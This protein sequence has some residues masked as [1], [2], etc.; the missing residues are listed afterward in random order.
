MAQNPLLTMIPQDP[1]SDV[2]SPTALYPQAPV[3][4][5]PKPAGWMPGTPRP[6]KPGAPGQPGAVGQAM[7]QG[8]STFTDFGAANPASVA[9][10]MGFSGMIPGMP[11]P[12]DGSGVVPP[13]G[14]HAAMGPQAP[15]INPTLQGLAPPGQKPPMADAAGKVPGMEGYSGTGYDARAPQGG[16]M[17]ADPRFFHPAGAPQAPE[18]APMQTLAD[19]FQMRYGGPQTPMSTLPPGMVPPAPLGEAGGWSLGTPTAP[20]VPA[21]MPGYAAGPA[22]PPGALPAPGVSYAG[23]SPTFREDQVTPTTLSDAKKAAAA[24]TA[25]PAALPQTDAAGSVK[26]TAGQTA[27]AA[28]ESAPAAQTAAST[29]LPPPQQ[30]TA[31][32]SPSAWQQDPILSNMVQ[33]GVVTRIPLDGQNGGDDAFN[34]FLAD[35][36]ANSD[37][38]AAKRL[39]NLR[40]ALS[41]LKGASPGKQYANRLKD[42]QQALENLQK[43]DWYKGAGVTFD[44]DSLAKDATSSGTGSWTNPVTPGGSGTGG[45]I[46]GGVDPT[47]GAPTV[48]QLP[49]PGNMNLP[50][51]FR[52]WAKLGPAGAQALDSYLK[53]LG[54]QQSDSNRQTAVDTYGAFVNQL[55]NDPTRAAL[56]DFL[57]N[58]AGQA[59]LSPEMIEAMKTSGRQTADSSL[60]A[61]DEQVR[62]LAAQT[63]RPVSDFAPQIAQGRANIMSDLINSNRGVDIQGAMQGANDRANQ[64]NYLTAGQGA[65]YGM[66]GNAMGSQANLIA[67]TPNLASV[68]F[69]W[70][71]AAV[72]NQMLQFQN[73]STNSVATGLSGM[74]SG[75]ASGAKIG[76][77]IPGI[78]TLAGGIGGGLLG[79]ASGFLQ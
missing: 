31:E 60:R 44:L 17:A 70:Q 56:Q 8:V 75:A 21:G 29:A 77:V 24:Q 32:A 74:L 7:R 14:F 49:D 4:G 78:G 54:M 3:P 46:P 16:G 19:R 2:A 28:P 58:Q 43:T 52:D 11:P 76:S 13:P 64:F 15:S 9:G 71:P 39:G 48:A 45:I 27:E 61:L 20:A 47:T 63:G 33:N 6:A 50:S 42:A 53:W 59:T 18:V 67:G 62:Q 5:Q 26:A 57:Q 34:K 12:P 37:P 1:E 30:Q 55:Q 69:G 40:N 73:P 51:E 41:Q 23:G 10:K 25:L 79:G 72:Q 22:M 36:G 66:L 65:L 68:N 38:Q 35:S